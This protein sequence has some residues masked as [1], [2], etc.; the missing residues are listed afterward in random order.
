M[1]EG[2]FGGLLH[3]LLVPAH[4]IALL[5]LG[6][7][8]GTHAQYRA[9]LL[10]FAAA[11]G[12]GLLAIA[13][14]IGQTPADSVVLAMAAITGMLVAAALPLPTFLRAAIAAIAGGAIGLDSPPQAVSLGAASAALIGTG[15]GASFALMLIAFIAAQLAGPRQRI[16]LRI[17]GS[18]IAASAILVLALR[19]ARGMLF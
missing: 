15:F 2:F 6:L 9:P 13:R 4:A 7:L 10:A 1:I 11:L 17:A 8:I 19:Y 3:P 16:G 12:L 5:G 14:G 18:W